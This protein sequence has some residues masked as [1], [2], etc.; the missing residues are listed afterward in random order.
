MIPPASFFL[1]VALAI[2]V[3]R[4]TNFRILFWFCEKCCLCFDRDRNKSVEG[5]GQQYKHFH[6]IG[7]SNLRPWNVFRLNLSLIF[8]IN[9]LVSRVQ[10]FYLLGYI[11]VLGGWFFCFNDFYLPE[12]EWEG[13]RVPAGGPHVGLEPRSLQSRPKPKAGE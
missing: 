3:S 1:E 7:S 4:S 10:V 13:R 8:S 2:M 9:V 11:L 6:N 5:F 12:H